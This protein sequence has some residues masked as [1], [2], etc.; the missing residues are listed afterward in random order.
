MVG[1]T[2]ICCK[3]CVFNIQLVKVVQLYIPHES[4]N[5][6]KP[7]TNSMVS[8][9]RLLSV[10]CIFLLFCYG[11]DTN[12]PKMLKEYPLYKNAKLSKVLPLLI[13]G[14]I[15]NLWKFNNVLFTS[16]FELIRSTRNTLCH[17]SSFLE[18]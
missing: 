8:M 14:F 12:W 10:K 2:I 18:V 16:S 9:S 3:L 15:F 11:I 6:T 7:N 1:L 17:V 4:L 13:Q 5:N